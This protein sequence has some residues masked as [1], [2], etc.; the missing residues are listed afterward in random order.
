MFSANARINKRPEQL[1]SE[2]DDKV[3][4]LEVDSG[5]Y[6]SFDE[7]ST[8]IWKR[9]DTTPLLA[10]LCNALAKD[11][12]ADLETIQMDVCKL[13]NMLVANNLIEIS[14]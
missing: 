6:F 12:D 2:I 4:L 8:D 10:D 5:Q 3:I 14:E 1:T 11:Y 9:L 7:V 13:I